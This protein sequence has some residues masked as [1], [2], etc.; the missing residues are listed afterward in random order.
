MLA[1]VSG[2]AST[3]EA[4]V[5]CLNDYHSDTTLRNVR[6]QIIREIYEKRHPE[7][8]V[9]LLE[10]FEGRLG[11]SPVSED[12]YNRTIGKDSLPFKHSVYGWDN[13]ALMTKGSLCLQLSLELYRRYQQGIS[14]LQ[15]L[16]N[17]YKQLFAL[18]SA[19]NTPQEST[20]ITSDPQAKMKYSL[21]MQKISTQI[22]VLDATNSKISKS[23]EETLE[24]VFQD[25]IRRN[26]YL[27]DSIRKSIELH[28][29]SL[30]FVVSGGQ[31]LV[32]ISKEIG[33]IGHRVLNL[34][35]TSDDSFH[36]V[37]DCYTK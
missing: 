20:L 21:A 2:N 28:P 23:I 14:Q 12:V 8:V 37:S 35:K 22:N 32:G 25:G 9:I 26:R 10:G 5:I 19:L 27:Y 3:Q 18:K 16:V 11:E 1:D 34:R 17:Q 13:T 7:H 6:N 36:A 29:Q 30:I 15:E 4:R 33:D 31:H 24:I